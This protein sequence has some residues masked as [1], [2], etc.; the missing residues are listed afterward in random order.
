MS[1]Q[2]DNVDNRTVRNWLANVSV[3][4]FKHKYI[5][6]TIWLVI[7]MFGAL[8]YTTLLKREGF[9]SIQ[10][11]ITL[12]RGVYLVDDA[13]KVD[14]QVA[15]P[16]SEAIGQVEGVDSVVTSA[17][18]NF[19]TAVVYTDDSLTAEEA[20]AS[21]QSGIEQASDIPEN[22]NIE[23]EAINLSKYYNSF[24]SLLA[25]YSSDNSMSTQQLTES[26]RVASESL[27][28]NPDILSATPVEQYEAGFNPLTG[29][30]AIQQTS[31]GRIGMY[32]GDEFILYNAVTI[33]VNGVDELGTIELADA[34]EDSLETINSDENL[35]GAEVVVSL[36]QSKIVE[37][38]ISSLQ[39]NM[40]MALI[41]VSIV[42]FLFI[43]WRASLTTA[44]FMV[45]VMAATL[46]TLL[47]IGYTLN[48]LVLF[49]LVLAIGLFVDDS[50]IITEAIDADK[51]AK[52]PEYS[53]KKSIRKVALASF[54]GT[55]TTILV[56]APLLFLSG[57][58]GNFIKLLPV[59]VIIALTLS[60]ILSLT[61]IPFLS[62]FTL[63]SKS[64]IK[65][66]GKL[67]PINKIEVALAKFFASIPMLLKKSKIKGIVVS[68]FMV[69][70][71]VVAVLGAGML[72]NNLEFNI[73]PESSDSDSLTAQIRYLPGTSFERAEA[74]ADELTT[75]I[76]A[77]IGEENLSEV[78]Y[79]ISMPPNNQ[80]AEIALTLVPFTDRAETSLQMIEEINQSL[81]GYTKAGVQVTQND[82]GPPSADTPFLMQIYSEDTAQVASFAQEVAEFLEGNQV[83]RA[84]G[85]TA[86]IT[87]VRVVN[88][89]GY[90]R[91]EGNR[92]IE[93]QVG[94]DAGDTSALVEGT[95]TMVENEFS[96]EDLNVYGLS[97]EDGSVTFDF[98]FESE[99]AESFNSLLLIIPIA[100]GMMFVLLAVQFRSLIK[101]I[102][103]F[104]AIPFSL[105]GVFF[106]LT[107]TDN[108]MSFFVMIGIIGLIGIVVNNTILLVDYANQAREKG[109][110]AI[111]AISISLEQRFRPL[112]VTTT[113]TVVALFPLAVYDPFWEPLA[114]TIMFGLMSATLLELIAFPYYYIVAD[115]FGVV[116][117]KFFKRV[118]PGSK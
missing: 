104:M 5:S 84:N 49:A 86:D 15:V 41:A 32:V 73:F 12:V 43:S 36:D 59:T 117:L 47:L 99:S 28:E 1:K 65:R 9:P 113:T 109:A 114:I 2:D 69:G 30:P 24:D 10:I 45:T 81:E 116:I 44:I 118:M 50:T 108:P 82:T 89:D 18:S 106:G 67:S 14:S 75:S 38:Q 77:I 13:Q 101:P 48:V 29:Q 97:Y 83:V 20:V 111:E 64:S 88:V 22:A 16:L 98:G 66:V 26:A 93:I 85:S 95:Q 31:Y 42:S 7:L 61:L 100:L 40:I 6:L 60:L 56:F 96:E 102:I 34:V 115:Y 39:E 25:T 91:K 52:T 27:V 78:T 58:M 35:N 94:F 105:F 21:I 68:I 54:A 46:G 33:G 17:Q 57:L 70:L 103:I 37:A 11:S 80:Q 71:S 3:F 8:S 92:Y 112:L 90:E 110:D 53:I 23:V 107:I 72:A 62:R 19:F 79:G 87:I 4:F 76:T 55:A 51:E 74:I 63:L